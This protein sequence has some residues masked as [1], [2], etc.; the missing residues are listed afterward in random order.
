M[1]PK[2]VTD[3]KTDAT[4]ERD[5]RRVDQLEREVAHM[6]TK[7]ERAEE[8]LRVAEERR[9]PSSS[10]NIIF[11]WDGP[12]LKLTWAA[13]YVRDKDGRYYTIPAGER[14]GLSAS[15]FYWMAWNPVHQVMV[16]SAKLET[17]LPNKNN[18]VICSL[19]TGTGG[20]SGTAGGGGSFGTGGTNGDDF[21]GRDYNFFP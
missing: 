11:V 8:K 12:N 4:Y 7:L 15:S 14:T 3:T 17:V 9:E 21:S 1:L 10:N 2:F 18:L 20:A 5:I 6:R 16:A 19:K 13:G